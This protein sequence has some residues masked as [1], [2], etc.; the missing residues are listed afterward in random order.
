M[1]VW[2]AVHTTVAQCAVVKRHFLFHRDAYFLNAETSSRHVNAG[3]GNVDPM[4]SKF[5]PTVVFK[6]LCKKQILT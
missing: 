1:V 6:K 4:R 5:R 2:Q 3:V